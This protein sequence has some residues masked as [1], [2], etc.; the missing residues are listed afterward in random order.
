MKPGIRSV[1][2]ASGGNS[3][4]IS[5]AG[6][7]AQMLGPWSARTCRKC[8][9]HRYYDAC[10]DRLKATGR[11]NAWTLTRSARLQI[12][13][14]CTQFCNLRQPLPA[15]LVPKTRLSKGRGLAC[16]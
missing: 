15:Q 7:F 10:S 16:A 5:K 8:I 4:Q 11:L 6:K 12:A 1:V 13:A 3:T 14:G 2:G 9:S